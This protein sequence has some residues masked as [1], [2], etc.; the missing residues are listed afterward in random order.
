MPARNESLHNANAFKLGLFG[1]NCSGG[2]AFTKLPERWD[3][4]WSNNLR[5][6]QLADEAGIECLVPIA[7]WKGHGGATKVNGESL[8][9]ITWACGLLAQTRNINV[10]GTVHVPLIHPVV[11]AKQM[12]TTDHVGQGRFGLNIVCGWNQD[13]FEMFGVPQQEHDVRYE[14]GAE[15]WAIVK[16]LWSGE[17]PSDYDGKFFHLK[18]LEAL[19]RPYRDRNPIMM[20]AGASPAGRAFAIHNSDLHFDGCERLE[21]SEARIKDTKQLAAEIGREVQ[22]WTAAS[23]VCRPTQKEVDDYLHRVAENAD[24]EAIDHLLSVFGIN[25]NM[26]SFQIEKLKHFREHDMARSILGYAG[27][28]FHISG[29]PDHV[30][31]ELNRYHDL[32]FD[33]LALHFVDYLGEMPYFVQEVMPRLER[34]GLRQSPSARPSPQ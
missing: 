34:M 13:E 16:Q 20:N 7:R 14:Y 12:A 26:R 28:S 11:A 19:P 10:F 27:G 3:P 9:T 15:W 30:A 31:R 23:I 18:A 17:G 1:P 21:D 29:D 2:L 24:W 22:V 4:S 8:E 32:G 5:L 6:A 25:S 33:G